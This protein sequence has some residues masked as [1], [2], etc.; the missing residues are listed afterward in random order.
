MIAS[1]KSVSWFATHAYY[2][3]PYEAFL[4]TSTGS[5]TYIRHPLDNA[6]IL[7]DYFATWIKTSPSLV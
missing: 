5:L 7:L 1:A 3:D 4:I 6:E 2:G